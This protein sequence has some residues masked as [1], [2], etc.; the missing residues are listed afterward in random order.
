MKWALRDF[1]SKPDLSLLSSFVRV[2]FYQAFLLSGGTNGR[3]A[4]GDEL[5]EMEFL[6]GEGLE[7]GSHEFLEAPT[8]L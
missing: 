8:V 4:R 7:D 6:E 5:L 3:L 2:K 1:P